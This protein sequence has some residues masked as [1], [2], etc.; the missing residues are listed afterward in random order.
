MYKSRVARLQGGYEWLGEKKIK[1][2]YTIVDNHN[3]EDAAQLLMQSA[4]I[5][6]L[7]PNVLLMGYKSN[8]MTC[9]YD[10]LNSYFTIL[11]WV[12]LNFVFGLWICNVDVIFE[13][14]ILSW[15]SKILYLNTFL[16]RLPPHCSLKRGVNIILIF[17][18]SVVHCLTC[19]LYWIF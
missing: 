1:G 15:Y 3:K 11:Q 8:W 13:V 9:P 19:N 17:F 12:D 7:K 5:G 18:S 2:F 4:G 6:K 14:E 16:I 10:D